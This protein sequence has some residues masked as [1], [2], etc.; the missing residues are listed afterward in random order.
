MGT[1]SVILAGIL[2][3]DRP[4][5]GHHHRR[6]RPDDHRIRPYLRPGRPLPGCLHQQAA[7]QAPHGLR[8]DPV[9]PGKPRL[10]RRPQPRPAALRS[11]RRRPR[12]S[13]VH[14]HGFCR[15][16]RPGRPCPPRP[17]HV[18]HHR[19]PDPRH[20]R[21]RPRR[22]HHRPAH[23]LEGRPRL[24]RRRRRHRAARDPRGPARPA[25]PAG[26]SPDPALHGPHRSPCRGPGRLHSAHQRLEHDLGLGDGHVHGIG[27]VSFA[28][29]V[30][31]SRVRHVVQWCLL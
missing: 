18:Q 26:G 12:G 24:R 3:L 31:G 19:R 27:G 4:R 28:R 16:L 10:R 7:P 11:N 2:P 20:R 13:P 17:G 14:A 23:L 1:D 6:R 15:C 22:N 30:S 8:P 29:S 25:H 9:R 21:R 5:L